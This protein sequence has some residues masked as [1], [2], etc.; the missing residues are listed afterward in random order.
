MLRRQLRA[1]VKLVRKAILTEI[2]QLQADGIPPT[3][4]TIASR[5]EC[6]RSTVMRHIRALENSGYIQIQAGV[7]RSASEYN[8]LDPAIQTLEVHS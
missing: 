8:L 6:G 1:D 5:V 7:G 3:W 4:E 2:Y